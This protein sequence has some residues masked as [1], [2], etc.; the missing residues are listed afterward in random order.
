VYD[1]CTARF[2]STSYIVLQTSPLHSPP[3]H[4]G[5]YSVTINSSKLIPTTWLPVVN[6]PYAAHVTGGRRCPIGHSAFCSSAKIWMR[7][8]M[9]TATIRMSARPRRSLSHKNVSLFMNFCSTSTTAPRP[10][11]EAAASPSTERLTRRK[12]K[13]DVNPIS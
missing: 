1:V 5:L 2:G 8:A 4:T 13:Y 11:A 10:V 6:N 3:S 7:A 9:T 12:T